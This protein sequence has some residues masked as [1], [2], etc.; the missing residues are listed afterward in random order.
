MP[1]LRA[2]GRR[3]NHGPSRDEQVDV[4]TFDNLTVL[5]SKRMVFG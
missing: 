1:S 3:L 4:F 5:A 2:F